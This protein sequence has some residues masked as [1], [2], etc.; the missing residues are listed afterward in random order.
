MPTINSS[1]KANYDPVELTHSNYKSFFYKSSSV[2][3]IT[4]VADFT[5]QDTAEANY[6]LAV[7]HFFKTA[8]KM[9][10]GQD[11]KNGGPRAGTPPPIFFLNGLGMHQFNQHPVLIS[12]FTYNLP[13]DVDYIRAGSTATLAGQNNLASQAKQS[14]GFFD[15]IKARLLGS[16]LNKGAMSPE[17]NF[18]SLSSSSVTYVPTKISIQLSLLPVVTRSDIS[19]R[20]SVQ[21]YAKGTLIAGS[22]NKGRGIW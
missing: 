21:E 5:A 22:Q 9:F 16:N 12:S 20:F 4:L 17:P 19:N 1:Y 3:D 10:Y 6:M 15:A 18:Q 13:N 14:T 11:G 7:I 2:E 8:T